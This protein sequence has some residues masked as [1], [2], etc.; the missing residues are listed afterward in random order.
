M[1]NPDTQYI[2]LVVNGVRVFIAVLLRG[3]YV[4]VS[5]ATQRNWYL[6][7]LNIPSA[8]N[9]NRPCVNKYIAYRTIIIKPIDQLINLLSKNVSYDTYNI[10][11]KF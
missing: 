2:M 7:K 4:Y 9:I 8:I 1:V 10:M 3:S 11:Y 6:G 5:V